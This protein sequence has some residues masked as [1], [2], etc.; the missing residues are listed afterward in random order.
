MGDCFYSD[1]AF[2]TGGGF[3]MAT[4][5]AAHRPVAE[6]TLPENGMNIRD[7]LKGM[8]N[9][10]NHLLFKRRGQTNASAAPGETSERVKSLT[11]IERGRDDLCVQIT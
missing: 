9:M 11:Y 10:K 3:L 4:E 7:V 5:V 8:V 6:Y 2:S 1:A